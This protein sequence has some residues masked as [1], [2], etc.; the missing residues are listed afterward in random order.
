MNTTTHMQKFAA[1]SVYIA[2]IYELRKF[3]CPQLL[4]FL[5]KHKGHYKVRRKKNKFSA[6]KEV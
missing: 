4:L 1:W 5:K 2:Q 3:D 6:K